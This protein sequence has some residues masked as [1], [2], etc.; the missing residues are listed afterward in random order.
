MKKMTILLFIFFFMLIPAITEAQRRTLTIRTEPQDSG[1]LKSY[2]YKYEK[3]AH[4]GTIT[5]IIGGSVFIVG[6]GIA[7]GS[8]SGSNDELSTIGYITAGAGLATAIT[9]A[10][11]R[12]TG[13]GRAEEYR[14]RLENMNTSFYF[15]PQYYITP[16]CSGVSLT[17]RF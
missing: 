16:K 4:N 5:M 9:G 8:Y 10:I 3:M 2:I 6:A 14:I 7:I 11:I 1:Y 17:L 13:R 15:K 12:S